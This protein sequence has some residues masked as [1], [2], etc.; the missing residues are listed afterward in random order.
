MDPKELNLEE[1]DALLGADEEEDSDDFDSLLAGDD[2]IFSDEDFAGEEES[3]E[4]SLDELLG[5]IDDDYL[6]ADE[7]V[8]LQNKKF[9]SERNPTELDAFFMEF[10][11]TLYGAMHGVY[12][13]EEFGYDDGM[14]DM[15]LN[16][17]LSVGHEFGSDEEAEMFFEEAVISGEC[18]GLDEEDEF[19]FLGIAAGLAAGVAAPLAAG[20]GLAAGAAVPLAAAAGIVKGGAEIGKRVGGKISPKAALF[21]SKK[22]YMREL[23]KLEKCV[24][25]FSRKAK[26]VNPKVALQITAGKGAFL[27]R[28][29]SLMA[30]A[31][32]QKDSLILDALQGGKLNLKDRRLSNMAKRCDSIYNQLRRVW[33]TLK[34]KGK[35]SG[36]K[37]PQSAFKDIMSHYVKVSKKA[38]KKNGGAISV[39][40]KKS[41]R[42]AK[43]KIA[44]KKRR[45]SRAAKEEI[46]KERKERIERRRAAQK[47]SAIRK[48]SQQQTL[49][50][51][52][53]ARKKRVLASRQFVKAKRAAKKT[54]QQEKVSNQ[55]LAASNPYIDQ[56]DL[57]ALN[58]ASKMRAQK[59]VS[60]ARPVSARLMSNPVSKIK[61]D[62]VKLERTLEKHR[63]M[64]QESLAKQ[65]KFAKGSTPYKAQYSK[66]RKHA[67]ITVKLREKIA[68]LKKK[69]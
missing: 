37:S 19:G 49:K 2:S 7:K 54:L 29:F 47:L 34:S 56:S 18:M 67:S 26:K 46:R 58:R 53:E 55:L 24:K 39:L 68:Q 20:A 61:S 45:D 65:Q 31:S 22:K 33:T 48:A 51:V 10:Q 16:A 64:H 21:A 17:D 15:E 36:L 50:D 40:S 69:L 35:T 57:A 4:D 59:K 9:M 6:T 32:S 63:K 28:P 12:G 23:S 41:M 52:R 62:I 43:A 5:A 3:E 44:L 11:E 1:I 66:T 42:K 27:K 30:A 13:D 38:M 14:D 25:K 8:F 60:A